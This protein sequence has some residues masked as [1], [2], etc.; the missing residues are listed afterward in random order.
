VNQA[1]RPK[2]C[3]VRYGQVPEAQYVGTSLTQ[4]LSQ[5]TEQQY[6]STAQ[7]SPAHVLHV[8]V[9]LPPAEQTE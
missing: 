1:A 8:E 2:T 5:S 9:S 4:I 3:D 7:T 6:G